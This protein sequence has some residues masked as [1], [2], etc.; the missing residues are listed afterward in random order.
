AALRE[1]LRTV[2][3]VSTPHHGTPLA[4]FFATLYGKKLLYF[5][6]LIVFVGL[7]R[8]P[9]SMAASLLGLG[10]R[11]YDFLGVNETMLRQLTNQL[12]RDFTPE[13]E[14]EVR[15]FLNSILE[16]VSLMVQLTPEAME[17]LNATLTT[18]P[19]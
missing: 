1:R 6:T 10:Y 12:L 19:N 9:V 8:Q 16:D 18:P 17:V 5:I 11:V 3:C 13:R 14:R 7:W 15:G 2:V 4:N